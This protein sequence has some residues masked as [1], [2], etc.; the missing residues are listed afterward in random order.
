M[1][2]G[3]YAHLLQR[4]IHCSETISMATTV[5]ISQ[6]F[7]LIGI[8]SSFF[9][10]IPHFIYQ[11]IQANLKGRVIVLLMLNTLRGLSESNGT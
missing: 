6:L 10:L 2:G 5:F 11:S 9:Q 3:Q 1:F 8:I 4:N 7:Y